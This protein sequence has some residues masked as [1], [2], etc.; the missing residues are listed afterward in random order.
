MSKI[1]LKV[2][3]NDKTHSDNGY[4]VNLFDPTL[5][6]LF[7]RD[8]ESAETEKQVNEAFEKMIESR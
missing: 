8:L 6:S 5:W 1:T 2:D 4:F 3:L 7:I